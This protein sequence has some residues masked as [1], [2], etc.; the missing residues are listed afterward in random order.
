MCTTFSHNFKSITQNQSCDTIALKQR[1][2]FPSSLYQ[3]DTAPT[4]LMEIRFHI[5]PSD[6][7]GD[8]PVEAFQSRILEKASVITATGETLAIFTEVHCL[9][10]RLV[11][12]FYM[13]ICS[14]LKFN[15]YSNF[16]IS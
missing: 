5:P 2:I 11:N 16:S 13:I 10:P 8:D 9:T 12:V 1:H 14:P 6:L 7:A 15:C 3:P 4:N